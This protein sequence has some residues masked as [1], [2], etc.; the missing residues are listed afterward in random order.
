MKPT[1]KGKLTIIFSTLVLFVALFVFILFLIPKVN[2]LKSVSDDVA[3]KKMEYESGL[4]RVMLAQKAVDIIAQA[5][6]ESALL[7]IAIPDSPQAEDAILQL[8]SSA[9]QA[10]L[11]V[12]SAEV[13]K[14]SEGV[15]SIAFST[16]GSYEQTVDFVS[17]LKTNLRPTK[18][19]ELNMTKSSDN[20]DTNFNLEF[21]YLYSSSQTPVASQITTD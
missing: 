12:I 18:I 20:I 21:P 2:Q 16:R 4:L 17:K 14:S 6:K 9:S 11:K 8:S 3:K 15:L 7:G 19:V 5:K 1:D 13:V 10:G